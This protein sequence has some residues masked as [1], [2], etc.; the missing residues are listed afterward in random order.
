MYNLIS[1]PIAILRSLS[2]HIISHR[3]LSQSKVFVA[4]E[5]TVYFSLDLRKQS[6]NSI[7]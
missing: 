1:A 6:L 5:A 7:I 3:R 4:S 2:I